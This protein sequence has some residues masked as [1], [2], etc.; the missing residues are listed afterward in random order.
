MPNVN[1]KKFPYTA[2][3]KKAAKKATASKTVAKK[4]TATPT[5]RVSPQMRGEGTYGRARKG[6]KQKRKPKASR[7]MPWSSESGSEGVYV[8]SPK[9]GSR[10]YL[11]KTPKRYPGM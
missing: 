5:S 7:V 6:M 9:K 11:T 1:G 8:R 2:A 10:V 4:T 3:G